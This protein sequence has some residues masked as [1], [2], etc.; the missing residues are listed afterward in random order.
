M[1]NERAVLLAKTEL[2]EEIEP[3]ILELEQRGAAS[4]AL[5]QK[6]SQNLQR[7]HEAAKSRAGPSTGTDASKTVSSKDAKRMS[8]VT[9]MQAQAEKELQALELEIKQIVRLSSLVT[10]LP[11]HIHLYS[12]VI[13]GGAAGYAPETMNAAT[14]IKH[15]GI[16]APTHSMTR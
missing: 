12:P 6:R 4:L 1:S 9:R 14:E 7:R 3:Q 15:L 11:H 10:R 16:D 8:H 5:V 2:A 13:L